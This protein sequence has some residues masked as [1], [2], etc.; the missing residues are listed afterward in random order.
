MLD[1]AGLITLSRA[2]GYRPETIET[3]A[4]SEIANLIEAVQKAN[5]AEQKTMQQH[6]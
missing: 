5:Q 2:S 1:L 4:M 6:R 3:M